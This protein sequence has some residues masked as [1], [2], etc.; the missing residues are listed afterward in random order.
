MTLLPY[1]ELPLRRAKVLKHVFS[2][3]EGWW[4]VLD[5]LLPWRRDWDT[6]RVAGCFNGPAADAHLIAQASETAEE[7]LTRRHEDW[8]HAAERAA[9]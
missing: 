7:V 6:L 9:A 2:T 1:P 5:G 8:L 3:A 4:V